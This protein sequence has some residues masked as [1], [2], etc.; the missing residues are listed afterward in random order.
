MQGILRSPHRSSY[1]RILAEGLE[2]LLRPLF[3]RGGA[4]VELHYVGMRLGAPVLSEQAC[5]DL[6]QTYRCPV[7]LT[8]RL[9]ESDE[10][11]TFLLG[12]IPLLTER[13]TLI[14]KGKEQTL[15]GQLLLAP[16]SYI[17]RTEHTV[18]DANNERRDHI[19][20]WEAT[21]RPLRGAALRIIDVQVWASITASAT[22]GH[23]E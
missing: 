23:S 20:T 7:R 4:G 19:P 13:D 11:Q 18:Y 14:V 6:E 22:F 8:L 16:G 5:L 10:V 3:P 17:E 1:A 12:E 9:A 2:R 15:I 21:I